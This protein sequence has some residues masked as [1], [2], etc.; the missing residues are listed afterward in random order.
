[1]TNQI[2]DGKLVINKQKNDDKYKR[3]SWD[4]VG[5]CVHTRNDQLASQNTIH[6][7]D[8]RVFS[9]RELMEMITVPKAFRW[10][11]YSLNELNL[12]S[13]TEKINI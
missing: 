11:E 6:P 4:K 12:L 7:S 13:S 5:P 1:M 10:S 2:I 3:Q 9:I 8:D